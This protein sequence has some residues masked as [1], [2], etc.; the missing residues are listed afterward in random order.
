M[1]IVLILSIAACGLVLLA[2]LVLCIGSVHATR[3]LQRHRRRDAGLADLLNYAAVVADGVI[4]GKNGAFL[5]AWVI[6]GDDNTSSTDE[7][8]NTVSMRI[9]Q[10]LAGL[11]NG[12]MVHVDAVRRPAPTYPDAGLSHFPDPV[13]AAID[14]E[15]RQLF[16]RLGT[17]YEG[18]FVLSATWML[19]KVFVE[20]NAPRAPPV[21]ARSANGERS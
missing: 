15:R 2:L 6:E 1:M 10:A 4:V 13:S 5:A 14:D 7:Q 21:S 11:G 20:M 17:M 8:R 9:N 19:P 16:E 18:Y 3:T 12:W